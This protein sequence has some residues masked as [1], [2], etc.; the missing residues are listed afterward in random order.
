MTRPSSENLADEERKLLG[1]VRYMSP[2]Q[3]KGTPIDGRSDLYALGVVL[4]EAL[5]RRRAT[6]KSITD[7]LRDEI[8]PPNMV[9]PEDRQLPPQ[10]EAVLMCL[11]ARDPDDRYATALDARDALLAVHDDL[12]GGL[13]PVAAAATSSGSPPPAA[14]WWPRP[15]ARCRGSS[16]AAWPSWTRPAATRWPRPWSASWR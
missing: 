10:L 7:V 9:L 3:A 14:R 16:R 11:L 5:T 6:G 12:L 15:R 2:E 1:T 4:Y 8:V 13:M